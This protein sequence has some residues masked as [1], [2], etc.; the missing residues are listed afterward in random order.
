MSLLISQAVAQVETEAPTPPN[1]LANFLPLILIFLVFYFLVIR[2][3]QKKI[4]SQNELIDSISKNDEVV[5]G[6]GIIGKVIKDE[7]EVLHVEINPENVVKVM[8]NTLSGRY[9]KSDAKS[10]SK[11]DKKK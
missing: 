4:K 1:A 8:R 11:K 6:G 3:Q 5:T 2:P 9:S 7:G 10:E